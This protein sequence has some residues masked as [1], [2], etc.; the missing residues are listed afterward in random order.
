MND[1]DTD[2]Y[3]EF[4]HVKLENRNHFIHQIELTNYTY[5][6][7]TINETPKSPCEITNGDHR[8]IRE[9]LLASG[10]L[11]DLDSTTR[12]VQ[13][14]PTVS[15]IKP[16]LFH[17]LEETKE[18]AEVKDDETSSK[19]NEKI[20]RLMIF[21][22]VNDILF[23]KLAMLGSSTLWT[24]KRTGRRLNGEKLLK[25]LCSEIDRL[26]TSSNRCPYDEDDEVK[27]IVNEEVNKNSEDWDKCYYELPG[28][29]L[30]IER[31]I[32]KDLIDE[33]V[34]GELGKR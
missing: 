21:D 7:A 18:Y 26:Q 23:H 29:V 19:S 28:L 17:L 10:F 27:D 13:L 31:L 25:E 20:R 9:I 34:N 11:K 22:F 12:I 8:Y 32:F 6:E 33:V 2:H 3:S 16:D 15:L 5:D 14:Q 24:G 1:T 4:N 30:D